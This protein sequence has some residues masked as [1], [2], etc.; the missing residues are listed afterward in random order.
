MPVTPTAKSARSAI[1][2][3]AAAGHD[4]RHANHR[5]QNQLGP[6]NSAE[7]PA[8]E[9]PVPVGITRRSP[10]L[11]DRQP[12]RGQYH[13]RKAAVR[14]ESSK[15]DPRP[16]TRSARSSTSSRRARTGQAPKA[17]AATTAINPLMPARPET[18][19]GYD[20]WPVIF[21]RINVVHADVSMR[22]VSFLIVFRPA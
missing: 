21:A 15:P 6:E 7:G 4:D 13:R 20:R 1:D 5:D 12:G 19:S 16:S 8:D 22:Q 11:G 3:L 14:Q 17:A 9:P 2:S 10:D 18:G